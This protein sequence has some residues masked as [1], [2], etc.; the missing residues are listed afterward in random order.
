MF[1]FGLFQGC[2]I[3]KPSKNETHLLDLCDL[4]RA[5]HKQKSTRNGNKANTA[6]IQV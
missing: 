5:S 6:N 1:Y 2:E 3:C 4:G